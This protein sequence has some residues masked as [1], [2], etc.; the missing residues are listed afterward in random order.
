MSHPCYQ[1]SARHIA[2][3]FAGPIRKRAKPLHQRIQ[4][5]LLFTANAAKASVSVSGFRYPVAP[6]K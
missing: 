6:I 5:K 1:T 4:A 2:V 3:L